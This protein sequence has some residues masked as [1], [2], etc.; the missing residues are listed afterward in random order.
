M[1]DLFDLT[2]RV[3]V[4]TGGSSG[5]GQAI[6]TALGSAGA[7]VVVVA[8]RAEAL[9]KTVA[10]MEAKGSRAAAVAADLAAYQTLDAAAKDIAQPLGNPDILVNAAG[11]NL[12]QPVEEITPE[13]WDQ[14]IAINLATP[15]FLAR[16]MVPA[17]RQKGWGRIVNIASLQ[18]ERA[19]PNS[20]PYGAS[21]GG[22]AQMTRAMAEAWSQHGINCNAI[23][24]GF[25]PTEL[26]ASVFEDEE[27]ATR[28][29]AQT[30]IGRNGRLDDLHG[31]AI[32]L[33]AP[34]SDYV[35][36]QV[37]FVD[38]GFTAK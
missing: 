32:F 10:T 8:R 9:A 30:A 4:V 28:I 14:T 22:V 15:F 17:M 12:R 35:T 34:A 18:S 25:F 31:T 13:S 20:L 7:A 19:F 27:R 1:S 2:G 16:A 11:I 36:G 23:A 37:I 33:A 29:A 26:T 3:A 6:A 24:P 38:G 21:K 5:I